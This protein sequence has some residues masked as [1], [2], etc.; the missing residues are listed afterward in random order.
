M[1]TSSP[2]RRFAAVTLALAHFANVAN[3]QHWVVGKPF[4]VVSDK[5]PGRKAWLLGLTQ[6]AE[7]AM[8]QLLTTEFSSLS[9]TLSLIL[10]CNKPRNTKSKCSVIFRATDENILL[11][12]FFYFFYWHTLMT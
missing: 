11:L 4:Q 7:K 9:E 2:F 8:E 12:L 6:R 3:F 10:S 1:A 5:E